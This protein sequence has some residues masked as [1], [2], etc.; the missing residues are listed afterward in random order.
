[1]AAPPGQDV[2][3]AAEHQAAGLPEGL[4]AVSEDPASPVTPDTSESPGADPGQDGASRPDGT[5]LSDA[6]VGHLASQ[7][8]QTAGA[9]RARRVRADED[10]QPGVLDLT[11]LRDLLAELVEQLGKFRL[12][13]RVARALRQAADVI[14]PPTEGG[15]QAPEDPED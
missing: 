2:T 9:A 8:R 12:R 13:D 10:G 14:D 3:Q 7:A 15:P 11:P 5:R 1:M 6:I 4:I